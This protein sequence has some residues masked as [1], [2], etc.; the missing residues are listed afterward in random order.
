VPF[1]GFQGG[2]RVAAGDVNGDGTPDAVVS[3]I[4]PQ[5][6]VKVFDGATGAQLGGAIG[7][8]FAFEGF[9]G[10]VNVA[11]SDVNGDG[12]AD[13]IAVANGVSGHVKAFS[14]K[15]GSLLASFLAYPGF[16]G[17]TTVAAADFDKDGVAE[18]VT[19]AASNGHVKVFRA[20]GSLFTVNLPP[21]I[22]SGFFSPGGPTPISFFAFQG[23]T[24]AVHV[25]ADPVNG[26]GIVVSTG[27]G[28]RGHVKLFSG[29]AFM[30]QLASFFAYP[31]GFAGGA[32]V[33]LADANNDG[34][35]DIRVTPGVGLQTDVLAFDSVALSP[36]GPFS[37]TAVSIPSVPAFANF[38]G[39]ATIAGSR[40]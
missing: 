34:I 30:S 33:A 40:F 13:A 29:P 23:F 32:F 11:T 9:A 22:V 16:T 20:D 6:H 26:P 8:F 25:A 2:V 3:A 19:V 36:G 10:D 35:S 1:A 4:F 39:G 24:G 7:S 38:L 12:L 14:G 17:A 28:T 21:T 31:T 18:I 5:G 15:D 27:A 37:S